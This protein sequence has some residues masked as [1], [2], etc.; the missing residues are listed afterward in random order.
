MKVQNSR[1][2]KA[3]Q[4]RVPTSYHGVKGGIAPLF[5]KEKRKK[6]RIVNYFQV[7]RK[8]K[9]KKSKKSPIVIGWCKDVQ[10]FIKVV[11]KY[12]F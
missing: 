1:H 12:D 8:E 10:P 3:T 11:P 5:Q 2:K 4:K 6:K 9:W 7:V